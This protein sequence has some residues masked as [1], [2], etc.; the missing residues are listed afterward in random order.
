MTENHSKQ[1][2]KFKTK[3]RTLLE[4]RNILKNAN[5]LP[6]V[7]FNKK[8]WDSNKEYYVS[9]VKKSLKK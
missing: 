2:D 1:L 5:I 3:A 6:M 8:E 7:I 9:K 4:L